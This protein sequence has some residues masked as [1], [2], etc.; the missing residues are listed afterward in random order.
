MDKHFKHNNILHRIFN[1]KTLKNK[2]KHGN[3]DM[4]IINFLSPM[5]I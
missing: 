3:L 2:L 1:R 4:L 5:N